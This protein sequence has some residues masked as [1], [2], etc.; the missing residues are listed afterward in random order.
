LP[1]EK[2]ANALVLI[3]LI[4]MMASVGLSVSLRDVPVLKRV[5]FVARGGLGNYFLVAVIATLLLPASDA[6]VAK[7]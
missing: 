1:V 4:E 3:L 7:C 6:V 5:R 2:I